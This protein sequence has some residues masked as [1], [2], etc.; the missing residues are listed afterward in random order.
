MMKSRLLDS[1]PAQT[2]PNEHTTTTGKWK[3]SAVLKYL[4]PCAMCEDCKES[5]CP[6]C[7]VC[8]RGASS[9]QVLEFCI[10]P[11]SCSD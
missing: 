3:L 4:D 7:P 5:N 9:G 11:D 8:S 10:T 2:T 6:K 1:I